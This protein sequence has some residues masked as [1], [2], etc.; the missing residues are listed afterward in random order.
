[1]SF[2]LSK[3]QI[4]YKSYLALYFENPYTE[5]IYMCFQNYS[6]EGVIH[7][8]TSENVLKF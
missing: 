1:M 8:N 3:L 5:E 7:N 6:H 4:I 2:F